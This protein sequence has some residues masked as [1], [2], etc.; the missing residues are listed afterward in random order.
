MARRLLRILAC[1]PLDLL[2]WPARAAGPEKAG[3]SQALWSVIDT[4][5]SAVRHSQL[6]EKS[7]RSYTS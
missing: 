2:N 6:D 7:T 3:A 5:L 1:P 4:S